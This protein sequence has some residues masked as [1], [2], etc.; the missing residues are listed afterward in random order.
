LREEGQAAKAKFEEADKRIWAEIK[1]IRNSINQVNGRLDQ[2]VK[3][4][5]EQILVNLANLNDLRKKQEEDIKQVRGELACTKS[6]Q[7]TI[8]A[9][10]EQDI[11]QLNNDVIAIRATVTE[12]KLNLKN[13][14]SM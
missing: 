10:F 7:A 2:E 12:H 9:K 11:K 6:N 13:K 3:I 14:S 8:N 4:L 5:R 1:S